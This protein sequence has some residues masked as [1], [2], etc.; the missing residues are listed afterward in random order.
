MTELK[1]WRLVATP[2][3]DPTSGDLRVRPLEESDSTETVMCNLEVS[4]YVGSATPGYGA[5]EDVWYVLSP[6]S[7]PRVL[8]VGAQTSAEAQ[9]LMRAL[10]DGAWV[11]GLSYDDFMA[12]QDPEVLVR[13][14][15]YR[16][17]LKSTVKEL[18]S[19]ADGDNGSRPTA[20]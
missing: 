1:T 12:S 5:D 14:R 3:D 4:T 20:A 6:D 9:G 19:V 11:D 7:R 13:R 18:E 8:V 15:L 17:A 10:Q 16:D 2:S